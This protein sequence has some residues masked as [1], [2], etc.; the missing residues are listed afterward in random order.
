MTSVYV[1][2]KQKAEENFRTVL[3]CQIYILQ[4]ELL[5]P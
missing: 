3:R 4:K 2:V 5:P 1:D